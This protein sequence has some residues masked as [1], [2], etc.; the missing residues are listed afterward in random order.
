MK[1]MN[2]DRKR[3][4]TK[5][6]EAKK[7]RKSHGL[8]VLR[9]KRVFGR[10]IGADRSREIEKIRIKSRW[11]LYIDVQWFLTN[12]GVQ[13]YRAKCRDRCRGKRQWQM[14]LSRDNATKAKKEARSI[15]QLSRSYWGS[16]NFPNQ[17]TSCRDNYRDCDKKQLKISTD[18][19]GA[20]EVSRLLKISFSRRE[21]HRYECNQVCNTTKDPNNILN[22]QNHLST[23]IFKHMDPEN[24]H[25][26]TH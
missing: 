24:T 26:H 5:W 14:K 12:R 1:C 17:S 23:T 11:N 7:G 3:D 13:R 25:T 19:P 21:K 10:W 15:H 9:E 2:N 18:R 6:F 20:E 8:K 4:H 16:R 22:F